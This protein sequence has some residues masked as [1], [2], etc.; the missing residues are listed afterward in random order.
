M[1][2]FKQLTWN[3]NYNW[4]TPHTMCIMWDTVYP[5]FRILMLDVV[6]LDMSVKWLRLA[7]APNKG[8]P[9]L[10]YL[11]A[12]FAPE[13]PVQCGEVLDADRSG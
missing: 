4:K 11:E 10:P 1:R 9:V 3:L 12:F 7:Q 2:T 8:I 5:N 6:S 13:E